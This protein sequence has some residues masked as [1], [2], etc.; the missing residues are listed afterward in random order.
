MNIISTKNT[1]TRKGYKALQVTPQKIA[2][3][4]LLHPMWTIILDNVHNSHF[5]LIVISQWLMWWINQ[6]QIPLIVL[7]FNLY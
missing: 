4:G 3:P 1:K 6:L 7:L 5:S 2:E